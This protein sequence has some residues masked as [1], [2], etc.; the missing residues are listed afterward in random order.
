MRVGR[1]PVSTEH[2]G[3]VKVSEDELGRSTLSE[4]VLSLEPWK[5]YGVSEPV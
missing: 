5:E 1:E 3:F 4:S 2:E